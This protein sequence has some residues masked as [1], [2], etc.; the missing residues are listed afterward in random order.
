MYHSGLTT[1]TKHVLQKLQ[2]R[3]EG[4]IFLVGFSLGGN[5]ALKLAGELGSTE[6]LSGVCAVSTPIDLAMAVRALDRLSNRIYARRFLKRLRE[7]VKRKSI[8]SP[9]LYS[10]DGVASVRSIWE[11]DDRFT[12]PLFGFETAS[13]YYATQSAIRFLDQIRT[14]TLVIAAKD[15]PLVPF[16]MYDHP[17]FT[18]NPALRLLAVDKGGHIGFLSRRKPRFWVDEVALDW[19]ENILRASGKLQAV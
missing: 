1:D 17:A 7:R 4:P 18:S 2:S 11:F 5:V 3:G 19:M 13:N 12:A 6:I 10:I 16:Q 8:L 9:E 14:P 15:D